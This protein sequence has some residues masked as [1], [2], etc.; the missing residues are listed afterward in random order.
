MSRRTLIAV[1][2]LLAGAIAGGASAAEATMEKVIGA[3]YP[4]GSAGRY[5]VARSRPTS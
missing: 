3:Y 2:V 5:P 1:A 4:G